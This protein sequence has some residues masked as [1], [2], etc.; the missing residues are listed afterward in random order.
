MSIGR[1][2]DFIFIAKYDDFR[3]INYDNWTAAKTKST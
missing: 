2:S 3:V 1:L